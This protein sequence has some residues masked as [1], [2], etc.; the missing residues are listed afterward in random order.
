MTFLHSA[1]DVRPLVFTS[2]GIPATFIIAPDG[3]VAGRFVGGADWNND[4]VID[5]LKGVAEPKP[6]RP[7]ETSA[8]SAK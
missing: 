8:T 1:P 2:E 5:F 6:T 7:S 3:Q 4:K